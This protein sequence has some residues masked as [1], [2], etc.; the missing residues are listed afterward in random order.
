VRSYE[1]IVE[2]QGKRAAKE[3]AK[4]VAA[5]TRKRGR[6]CKSPA[7]V[8]LKTEKAEKNEVEVVEDE[9]G[10]AGIGICSPTLIWVVDGGYAVFHDLL[11]VI[12]SVPRPS[13]KVTVIVNVIIITTI[14]IIIA[15]IIP[16]LPH[17]LLH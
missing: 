16:T 9:I 17:I 11:P 14:I 7:L 2:A 13:P 8:G 1:D 5:A 3:A 12:S 4:V 6:K 10:A 15:I